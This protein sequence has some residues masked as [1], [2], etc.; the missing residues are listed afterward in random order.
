MSSRERQLARLLRALIACCAL[1]F[2]FAPPSFSAASPRDTS[3]WIA[4]RVATAI[5]VRAGARAAEAAQRQHGGAPLATVAHAAPAARAAA[6]AARA[7]A[8]AP[9]GRR[10]IFDARHL[11]LDLRSLLC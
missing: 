3:G 11:Y 1:L 6:P 7:A 8:P 9:A 4:E 10:T 5:V 2:A